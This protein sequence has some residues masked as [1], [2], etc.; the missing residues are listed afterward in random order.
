MISEKALL[1]NVFLG[2]Y[3]TSAANFDTKQLNE[4]RWKTNDGLSMEL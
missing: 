4:V 1:V 3:H 2:R